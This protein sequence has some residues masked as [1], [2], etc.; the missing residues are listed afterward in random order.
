MGGIIVTEVMIM[1][2]RNKE[3]EDASTA[4]DRSL[5]KRLA[6]ATVAASLGVSLGV[7]V[8]RVLA[9]DMEMK[10]PPGYSVKDRMKEQVDELESATS[11][12]ENAETIDLTKESI[13]IRKAP[14]SV[15]D[16]W[17]PGS[18]QDKW[19]PGSVQDKW[20]P[21]S[22]Q[23]KWNPGSDQIK[24]DKGIEAGGIKTNE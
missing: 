19:S 1:A 11:D 14:G 3:K 2:K 13:Q 7:P 24:I 6:V 17:T 10:N 22:S 23:Y 16:K 20:S 18:V 21:G 5:K 4:S 12:K 9:Q 8:G 15:Q